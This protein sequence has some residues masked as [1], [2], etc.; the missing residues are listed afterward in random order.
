MIKIG[1][2][3]KCQHGIIG[4]V[5]S[6]TG[7]CKCGGCRPRMYKGIS[8]NGKPWQSSRPILVAENI[9]THI[10]SCIKN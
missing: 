5:A 9:E 1:N 8:F 7:G 3:C 6:I 2:V 4:V 10:Q